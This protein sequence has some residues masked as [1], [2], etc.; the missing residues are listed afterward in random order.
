MPIPSGKVINAHKEQTQR[1]P[2]SAGH[3]PALTGSG[4]GELVSRVQLRDGMPVV[5]IETR[6]NARINT[7]AD[8]VA[9]QMRRNQR[10]FAIRVSVVRILFLS[11]GVCDCFAASLKSCDLG[12]VFRTGSLSLAF[13]EVFFGTLIRTSPDTF[14]EYDC[15][16]S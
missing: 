4:S 12:S 14:C 10:S 16:Q 5:S 15:P 3:N 2:M 9:T 11:K 8:A 7:E 6:R 1:V 13:F